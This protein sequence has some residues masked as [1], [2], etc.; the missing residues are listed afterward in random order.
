M[1][2]VQLIFC[3]FADA[4]ADNS[5][6]LIINVSP[7]PGKLHS[8]SNIFRSFPLD[9]PGN[10]D[11]KLTCWILISWLPSYK[12][13]LSPTRIHSWFNSQDCGARDRGAHLPTTNQNYINEAESFW[14]LSCCISHDVSDYIAYLCKQVITLT[15]YTIQIWAHSSAPT[16]F[17]PLYLLID[18]LTSR[19]I[20]FCWFHK[21]GVGSDLQ[22]IERQIVQASQVWASFVDSKAWLSYYKR[23]VGMK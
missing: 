6:V 18:S 15:N 10:P 9:S 1:A 21:L 7:E 12:R 13:V 2:V 3:L 19:G 17:S 22:E 14:N 23:T 8:I 16:F 20:T 11:H 5:T 4:N